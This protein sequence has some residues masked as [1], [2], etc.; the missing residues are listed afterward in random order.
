MIRPPTLTLPREGGGEERRRLS[1]RGFA[2][3][4]PFFFPPSPSTGE[5]R[6]EGDRTP[7]VGRRL[8]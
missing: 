3:G 6:G 2:Q 7:E 8:A 5:G 1:S 4:I